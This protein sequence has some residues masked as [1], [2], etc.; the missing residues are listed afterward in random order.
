[1]L[2]KYFVSEKWVKCNATGLGLWWKFLQGEESH[3]HLEGR[4]EDRE[5]KAGMLKILRK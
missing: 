4:E 5:S 2:S 3:S 1:L